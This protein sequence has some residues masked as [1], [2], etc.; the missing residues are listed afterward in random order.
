MLFPYASKSVPCSPP[1]SACL[2]T[3][4]ET[5]D[6]DRRKLSF[7]HQKICILESSG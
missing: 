4:N 2:A 1:R 7:H 5:Y 3:Q 6:L